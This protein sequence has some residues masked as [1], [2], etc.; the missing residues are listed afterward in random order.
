MTWT[1]AVATSTELGVTF[2]VAKPAFVAQFYG[3]A[4]T[5]T[6]G[7]AV[8]DAWLSLTPPGAE[9]HFLHK[10]ARSYRKVGPKALVTIRE[11][12]REPGPDGQFYAIKDAPGF[13]A[14][15]VAFEAKVGVPAGGPY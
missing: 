11:T 2:P 1:A 14:G 13:A 15:T 10:K 5:N 3:D 4:A 9:L 6:A 7:A 8:F 12:L